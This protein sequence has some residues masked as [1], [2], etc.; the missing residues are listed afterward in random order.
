[1]YLSIGWNTL[2]P[3]M[4]RFG[5]E[6]WR[7]NGKNPME[8][9]EDYNRNSPLESVTSLKIPLLMWCGKEDNTVDWRQS[10]EYFLA[11]RRLGKKNIL[12]VYPKEGHTLTNPINQED[13]SNK[14]LQWFGHYLKDEKMDDW[15]EKGMQ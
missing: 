1:M 3:E 12:L 4:W 13:L 9:P 11:L 7:F 8:N 6:Q 14:V 10:I 5:R 2:R 15:I